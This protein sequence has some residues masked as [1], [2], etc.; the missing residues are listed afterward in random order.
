LKHKLISCTVAAL[1]FSL[2]ISI[3]AIAATPLSG[4]HMPSPSFGFDITELYS[5]E[6]KYNEKF[7][8]AAMG[9]TYTSSKANIYIDNSSENY[10]TYYSDPC[11]SPYAIS[12]DFDGSD[13]QMKWAIWINKCLID[14]RGKSN[15]FIQGVYTH[16]IGHALGLADIDGPTALLTKNKSIMNYYTDFNTYYNPMPDDVEAVREVYP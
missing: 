14:T 1:L 12:G 9:W 10:V 16:E 6:Q 4:I 7:T 3:I 8:D 11:S 13:G 5:I 2:T 15:N